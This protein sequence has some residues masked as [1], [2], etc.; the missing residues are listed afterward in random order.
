MPTAQQW[1]TLHTLGLDT[2]RAAIEGLAGD[3]LRQEVAGFGTSL[4]T[5]AEH[6]IGAE[7]YWLREVRIEPRFKPPAR[8]AWSEAASIG[9]YAQ[10]EEQYRSILAERGLEKN[11]LFGLGR[12]CQ[13]A[14]FHAVRMR[15]LRMLLVPEWRPPGAY[16][17][18]GW[19]RAVDYLSDLLISEEQAK[20]RGD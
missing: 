14:L 20:V 3:Q 7:V 13:H 9:V 19:E 17:R 8:E 18:A 15:R 5:E 12:V 6:V 11:I 16:E 10:I 1:L 2:V 4:G